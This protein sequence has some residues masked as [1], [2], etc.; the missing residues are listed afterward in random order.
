MAI[1]VQIAFIV[2]TQLHAEPYK[3]HHN[4]VT[5]GMDVNNYLTV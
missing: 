4:N 2:L 5:E 1:S 3:K